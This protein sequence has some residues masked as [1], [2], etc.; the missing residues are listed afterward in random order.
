LIFSGSCNFQIQDQEWFRLGE[1]VVTLWKSNHL[2]PVNSVVVIFVNTTII[3]VENKYNSSKYHF[4]II[5]NLFKKCYHII[6]IF[7][8]EE[9]IIKIL[10]ST[11]T[12]NLKILIY[13][14]S[15]NWFNKKFIFFIIKKLILIIATYNLLQCINSIYKFTKLDIPLIILLTCLE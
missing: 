13:C 3:F 8:F 11:Y 4:E 12:I 6:K 1:M 9:H 15:A 7:F 2:Y 5:I 14:Q 10:I